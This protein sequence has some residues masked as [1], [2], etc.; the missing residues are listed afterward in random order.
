MIEDRNAKA[1]FY[2]GGAKS[3]YGTQKRR[4]SKFIAKQSVKST[5]SHSDE[6]QRRCK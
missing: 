3:I 1:T 4:S 2:F 5:A 6:L